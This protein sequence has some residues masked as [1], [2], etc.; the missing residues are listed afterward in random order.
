MN[1]FVFFMLM[2]VLAQNLLL[3]YLGWEGVGL[4]SY[5]LIG[6]W[7][8]K[9]DG[10]SAAKKAFIVNAHRRRRDA[11]RDRAHLVNFGTLDFDAVFS[12]GGRAH[13]R[14]RRPAIALLL[15]AGAV[16]KS[17]Q[18]PLQWLPDAMEGPTPVS[19]LIHAATMVTAGVYLVVRTHVFFEIS[20]TALTVVAIGLV[21][22]IYAGDVARR[23]GRHQTR[24]AYSTISQIGYMFR[25]RDGR[26]TRSRSSCWSPTRSTRR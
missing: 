14:E 20:G 9:P 26:A 1:L 15:L 6:F 3:L 7:F 19:A 16:G 12:S 17:A 5:L 22:A 24:L 21:T 8:E 10:A 11:D 2:L 25:G 18:L 13:D 23:P 4:C